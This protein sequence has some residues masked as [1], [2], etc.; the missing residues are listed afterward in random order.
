LEQLLRQKEN[1]TTK[2]VKDL[3]SEEFNVEYT[4]KQI[5]IILRDMGMNF[6]KPYP[7]DYRRPSNAKEMLKKLP[8][9]DQ[10]TVIGFLDE[11]SRQTTANTQRLWSYGKPTICKNTAKIRANTFGFYALNGNSV[12]DF[13]PNSKKDSVCDF[14]KTVW[15]A[16]LGKNIIMILDIFSRIKQKLSDNLQKIMGSTS[17]ICHPIHPT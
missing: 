2:D 10:N 5:Y 16:N 13:K 1:W 17:S 14:L 12:I 9:M 7:H 8:K 11:T 15:E 3:I 4:L 6:A